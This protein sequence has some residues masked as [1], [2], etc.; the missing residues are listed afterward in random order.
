MREI[1]KRVNNTQ[2]ENFK[3]RFEFRVTVSNENGENMICQRYFKIN[4]FNNA[5]LYSLDLKEM[6]DECVMIINEDLKSKSRIAMFYNALQFFNSEDE[7]KIWLQNPRHTQELEFGSVFHINSNNEKDDEYYYDDEKNTAV[8]FNGKYDKNEYSIQ[9]EDDWK[10]VFKFAFYDNG[11]EVISKIWDAKY[12]PK[13]VC[14][15]VDIAN[16]RARYPM[17]D[18]ITMSNDEYVNYRMTKEKSDLCSLIIRTIC[19]FCSKDENYTVENTVKY[20]DKVY[21]LNPYEKRNRN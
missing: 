10:T 14:K 3:E 12:Y 8:K 20:G 17:N 19:D 16:K 4:N 1:K 9:L 11:K 2:N 21:V 5:I 15:N 7:M 18:I 6:A 13:I